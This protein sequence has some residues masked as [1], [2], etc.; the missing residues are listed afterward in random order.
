MTSVSIIIPIRPGLTPQALGGVQRLVWPAGQLELL[1]AEGENPS[2]Q[3]NQAVAQASGEIVYFLDDDSL[4]DPDCL[5]RLDEHFRDPTVVAVGGPSCT[6]TTDSLLQR[7]I[8]QVLGTVL[9]AGGVR[10]R[11]RAVGAVR[12]TNERELIL[13]NLA[14]RTSS[15]LACGGLDERL[16]PNEENEF[17]DRLQAGGGRLLHDPQLAVVRSQRPTLAA[18]AR[19]M[20]RYGRGR[21]RQTRLAGVSGL[22]PFVPL[23]FILYLVTIPLIVAPLWRLPLAGYALACLLCGLKAAVASREPGFALLVP[24]LFP[25]LH[26]ANGVG[27]AAGFLLPLPAQSCYNGG[28]VTVRQLPLTD[29]PAG[30]V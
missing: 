29:Q 18:F 16:Y 21:A 7:A 6:P 17:L 13:C 2:R 5:Q 8:G 30:V 12:E 27:L 22:M 4:V 28:H 24:L 11:Y 25:L 10:N 19:Q 15:F 26:L 23:A 14:V 9:G 20:F 3:R 1:V